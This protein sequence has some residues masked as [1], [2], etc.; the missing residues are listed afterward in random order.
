MNGR[1][2]G[3][4]SLFH[5]MR[6]KVTL[7]LL[8]SLTAL[9]QGKI[10]LCLCF[11]FFVVIANISYFCFLKERFATRLWVKLTTLMTNTF[12]YENK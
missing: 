3:I 10:S 4:E 1:C 2:D 6:Y 7:F 8:Q 11:Y 9:S 12:L 5:S